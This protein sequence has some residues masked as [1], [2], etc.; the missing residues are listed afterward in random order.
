LPCWR[1][2]AR[3]RRRGGRDGRLDRRMEVNKQ[4]K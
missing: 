2:E 4:V 3:G 1:H